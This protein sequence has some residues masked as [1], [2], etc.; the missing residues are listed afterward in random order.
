MVPLAFL[1]AALGSGFGWMVGRPLV[2]ATNALQAAEATFR[3]G[4]SRIREN[5]E[6][7]ALMRGEPLERAHSTTRFMQVIREYK[8]QSLAYMGLVSFGTGYGVL[9]PVFPLLVAAPQYIRG[10]MSLG[11]LMQAAQAFQQLTSALSWPVDNIGDMARCRA[12]AERVLSLNEAMKKLDGCASGSEAVCIVLERSQHSRILIEDLCIAEP[13]GRI[14][15]EHFS[16]DIRRGES[17]LIMG[18]PEVTAGLFKVLAG[19]WPWGSGRVKLPPADEMLFITQC[20]ILD[21]KTLR[22]VLCYPHPVDAFETSSIRH[23]LECA[24]L[25]WVATRIDERNN[26]NQVLPQRS[27]QRLCFA[28]AIVQQP[29]WICMKEVLDVFNPKGARLIL[30]MLKRELPN[31]AL[32][33][34]SFQSGLRNL[35]NRTIA[36]SRVRAAKTIE[37]GGTQQEVSG[38]IDRENREQS[39]V[40]SEQ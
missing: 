39:A 12:S 6:T 34:I 9:L 32:L 26:W 37:S 30:E 25:A 18:D 2:S 11:V 31:A 4:L 15:I 29:A 14:L 36:L 40:G 33:N 13:S 5:T 24:G 8:R 10:V 3:Y 27:L 22:E 16:A 38:A 28:R 23:G 7:I 1:Y 21:E 20:H 35:H 17:V 19:I